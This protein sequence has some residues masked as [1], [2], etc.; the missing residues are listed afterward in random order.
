M[1]LL[2]VREYFPTGTNGTLWVEVCKTIELPW[3]NNQHNVS[4]VPE[5]RYAL[6]RRV[7]TKRGVHF[8]VRD[9]RNRDA[10]LIHPANDALRELRGCIAPVR[11][12]TGP[13]RG[14]Q[15]RDAMQHLRAVLA[16]AFDH[17][18]DVFLTIKSETK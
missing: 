12:T 16:P 2:L 14:L 9:V 3:Q 7:T 8:L 11:Y 6:Q 15:S 18:E 13:G 10:I 17:D 1:N 5:E 4:C